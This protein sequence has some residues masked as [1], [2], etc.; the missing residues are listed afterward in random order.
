MRRFC[1][2]GILIFTSVLSAENP[3]STKETFVFPLMG[4]KLSSKYGFRIHPIK[5][6]SSKH[7]GVDLAAP[8]RA[9]VFSVR[10]G[11]VRFAGEYAGFGKLVNIDHGDGRSSL[12]GHLSE[13]RVKTGQTIKAGQVIGRVGSTGHSTGPHLHFEWRIDGKSVD[14]LEYF[15]SMA[16]GAKG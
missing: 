8:K 12:Y 6:F 1:C 13:I 10:S 7:Q 9:H 3:L 15:P 2:L 11:I 16:G 14:P 5:K 4:P